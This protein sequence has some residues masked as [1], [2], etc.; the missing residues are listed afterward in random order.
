MKYHIYEFTGNSCSDFSIESH[1]NQPI[2]DDY[3][4]C[5]G[6]YST[7]EEAYEEFKELL[8]CQGRYLSPE[9]YVAMPTREV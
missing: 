1:E 9:E 2:D 7:F 8:N 3:N 6:S 5:L 4:H